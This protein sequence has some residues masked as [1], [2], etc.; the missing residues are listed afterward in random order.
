VRVIKEREEPASAGDCNNNHLS[1][2][3]MEI[4]S[5]VDFNDGSPEILLAGDNNNPEIVSMGDCNNKNC[6][7][8]FVSNCDSKICWRV[9]AQ[10]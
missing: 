5:V 9:T 2:N 4:M 10:Q 1:Y 3:L 8:V 6:F 7:R